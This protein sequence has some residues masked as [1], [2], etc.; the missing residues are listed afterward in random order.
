MAGEALSR[1]Q[2]AHQAG[3]APLWLEGVHYRQ[4]GKVRVN[5]AVVWRGEEPCFPAT[6]LGSAQEAVGWY[7]RL[8]WIEEMFLDFKEKV[9]MEKSK[10]HV[11]GRVRRL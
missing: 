4:D 3:E 8:F 2:S 5:I 9:G 6:S 1:G 7:F 11:I 10:A